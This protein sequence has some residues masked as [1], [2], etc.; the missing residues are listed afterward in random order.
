MSKLGVVLLIFVVL[1]ALT[2]PHHYGNRFAGYQARQMG[3]QQRKNALANALRRSG[4]GYLG[5]PCC[6][7]PKRAYCHGDLECNNIAMCVN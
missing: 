4:C 2:S 7:A 6:V 5:E 3:V 1:L